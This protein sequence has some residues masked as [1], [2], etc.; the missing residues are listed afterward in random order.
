MLTPTLPKATTPDAGRPPKPPNMGAKPRPPAAGPR[1]RGRR[2]VVVMRPAPSERCRP[3]LAAA[4][5][6][7]PRRRRRR[8]DGRRAQGPRRRALA[9][10]QV[11][12]ELRHGLFARPDVR[13]LRLQLPIFLQDLVQHQSHRLRIHLVDHGCT[14]R[15]VRPSKNVFGQRSTPSSR[16]RR[17]SA[18]ANRL[19]SPVVVG[20]GPR[21]RG[22][23]RAR[24][25]GE[26]CPSR[27][28][29]SRT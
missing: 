26:G 4:E 25:R 29:S 3:Q 16:P 14:R 13:D 28:E 10:V 24:G 23:S 15:D 11:G 21:G 5:G 19:G 12:Q 1:G 17:V 27:L 7:A 22:A 2:D 6:N 20:L 8:R 18:G 9:Q